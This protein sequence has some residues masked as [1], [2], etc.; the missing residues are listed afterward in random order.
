MNKTDLSRR[1]SVKMSTTQRLSTQFL[2]AFQEV[3]AEELNRE[4]NVMLQG[5]GSFN[6]WEQSAR[7]GR[8][9]RNGADCM[10]EP[11]TSVKFR[12]GKDL[13]RILNTEK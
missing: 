12:P 3:V 2:N 10:I 8:N 13:L 4:G 11:R 6:R 9:P 5:F 7:P 1:L